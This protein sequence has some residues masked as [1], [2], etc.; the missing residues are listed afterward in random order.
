[1]LILVTSFFVLLLAVSTSNDVMEAVFNYRSTSSLLK[2]DKYFYGDLF[3]LSYLPRFKMKLDFAT[4]EVG[5]EKCTRPRT[6]NL[7][8]A[9]DSYLGEYY[10]KDHTPFCG[11]KSYRFLRVNLSEVGMV[12]PIK[13]ETNLLLVEMVERDLRRYKDPDYL[14]QKLRIEDTP[15]KLTIRQLNA[16]IKKTFF[17][18]INRHIEYNLF[19]YSCFT[20]IKEFKASFNFTF[21]KRIA[22]DVY[23]PPDTSR[24]LF[25]PTVDPLSRSS[26]FVSISDEEIDAIVRSLN[27]L[28]HYYTKKG[29][30][31][32]YFSAIP[33]P[34]S[35]LYPGIGTYNNLIPRIQNHPGLLIP[36]VNI[37]DCF[38]STEQDIYFK[39]DSHWNMNGFTLWLNEFNKILERRAR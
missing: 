23:L 17:N 37:Y 3:G 38:T 13:G 2:S 4:A 11:V 6:I 28:H 35:V 26:S 33:N 20:P 8:V 27:H 29:F 19:S 10:V 36:I 5:R 39:N 24:L 32:V 18:E 12:E 34:V 7:F 14:L 9:G 31:E 25:L 22:G 16:V 1:M 21:F 15:V 30:D